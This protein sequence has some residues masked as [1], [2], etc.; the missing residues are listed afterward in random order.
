[1]NPSNWDLCHLPSVSGKHDGRQILLPVAVFS[2]DNPFDL[3]HIVA[4]AL[5]DTGATS[6]GIGP[7]VVAKLGL[8]S[9]EKR[10]LAVA[11]EL[12]MVDYFFFRL[13]L[14]DQPNAPLS[15]AVPFV[16]QELDGFGWLEP[17]AFDIILGMDV[18]QQCDLRIE[19]SKQWTL[20]FGR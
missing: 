8:K 16:F 13:G 17:R 11:T 14:F 2:S 3:T 19:R 7:Q 15:N 9:F 10:P 1:M 5:L 20:H 12:R 6:S 4:R 18:L